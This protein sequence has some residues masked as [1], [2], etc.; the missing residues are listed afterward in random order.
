MM[1]QTLS[2]RSTAIKQRDLAKLPECACFNLRK[3][4]RA[5]TQLY[6]QILKPTG[7]RGTQFSLLAAIARS[8]SITISHLA[9]RLV[10]ERTTLTRNLRPL[11]K[12]GLIK[13]VPGRDQRTRVVTLTPKGYQTLDN[14]LPLWEKAQQR[15]ESGL[16][17]DRFQS[18]LS[19]LAETREIAQSV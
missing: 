2:D 13:V 1:T 4:A 7:L 11:D 9:A 19:D 10:M 12:Q 8:E 3:T 14:T 17:D 6:D 16:G 18:M 15:F 5:V